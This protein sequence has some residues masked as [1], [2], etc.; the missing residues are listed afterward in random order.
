VHKLVFATACVLLAS[1]C[2]S[3]GSPKLEG[4]WK[5]TK[6]DGVASEQQINANVFATGTEIIARGNQI[7]VTTPIGKPVQATYFVDSEDKTSVVIH[8]D[9]DGSAVRETFTFADEG[10]TMTW[11]IDGTRTMTFT[12]IAR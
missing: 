8:T 5:G 6:T 1:G 11:K 9:K 2:K 12:R 4:R 7:A 10:N 3:P